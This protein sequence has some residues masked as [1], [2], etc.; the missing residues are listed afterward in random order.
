MLG[1]EA[2]EDTLAALRQQMG[3]DRP[4]YERYLDWLGGM[5]TG[6]LGLSMTYRVSVSGGSGPSCRDHSSGGDSDPDIYRS[7]SASR[8]DRCR[9]S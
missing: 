1:T 4:A 6:D 5:L 9:Q 3:L 8:A 7:C 2:R